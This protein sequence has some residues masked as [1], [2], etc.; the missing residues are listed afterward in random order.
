MTI[1]LYSALTQYGT[2]FATSLEMHNPRQFVEW[3][4]ENYDY[5]QYNPR[6]PISRSGL[7]LTSLDG[8]VSGVPDLDSLVEYNREHGTTHYERD[9]KT[10]TS[11]SEHPDIVPIIE[12]FRAHIFRSH[13]IKLDPGGFFPPH[14]DFRGIEFDSF[15]L[16]VPL[17]NCDPP[18]FTFVIDD[19][20]INWELGRVYFVDTVKMH[21][22]FNASTKPTYFI[23]LN[24]DLNHDTVHYCTTNLK[25]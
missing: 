4:E 23:V 21:Y 20:I 8:G 18:Q 3:T 1:E 2:V 16:L 7:S 22:L 19:K 25:Y 15:R 6:K 5:V 9:F 24:V 12:P 17:Q 13:I 11:V 14:R 10:Y